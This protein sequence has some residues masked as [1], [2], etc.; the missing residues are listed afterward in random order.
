MFQNWKT[1]HTFIVL[2]AVILAAIPIVEKLL[3]GGQPVTVAGVVSAVGAVA[4][5]FVAVMATA[6]K[7]IDA[8]L[9]WFAQKNA[10]TPSIVKDTKGYVKLRALALGLVLV[11]GLVF[12]VHLMGCGFL[13]KD[14][15]FATD[16]GNEAQCVQTQVNAG[17]TD[18]L[19]IAA[20]CF[21]DEITL[22]FDAIQALLDMPSFTS[23]IA[24]DKLAA[25]RASHAA[26]RAQR[27]LMVK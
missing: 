5:T 7:D 12:V 26:V 20:N 23:S 6:P 17:T 27:T 3:A 13:K 25:L 19:I 10:E 16:L 24:P 18:V 14:P 9:A 4:I 1:N 22:A 21:G 2:A 8:V 15:Q 11:G